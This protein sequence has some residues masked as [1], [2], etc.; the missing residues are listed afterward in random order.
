[1]LVMSYEILVMGQLICEI[2][3]TSTK[4]QATTCLERTICSKSE[5]IAVNYGIITICAYSRFSLV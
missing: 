2:I 5:K 3:W 4:Y 1:I